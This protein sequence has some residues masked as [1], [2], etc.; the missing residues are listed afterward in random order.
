MSTSPLK[1]PKRV[2]EAVRVMRDKRE[3][4]DLSTKRGMDEYIARKKAMWERQNHLCCICGQ[5]PA[6]VRSIL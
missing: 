4:C 6:L 3:V 2:K 1:Y 5:L